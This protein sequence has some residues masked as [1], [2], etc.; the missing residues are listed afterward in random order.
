MPKGIYV[1]TEKSNNHL[2]CHHSEETKKLLSE[3]HKANPTKYWL[4]KKRPSLSGELHPMWKGG[5]VKNSC[6]ICG[7]E[8]K[9][10]YNIYCS[11]ICQGK[12]IKGKPAPMRGR[13]RL[14]IVGELNG[15]WKGGVTPLNEKIRKSFK[16]VEW[17][18]LIKERD[19]YTCQI[20]GKVGGELHSDHLKPFALYPDLRFDINNGRTLCVGCH[21]ATQTYGY[22][23]MYYEGGVQI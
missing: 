18:K 21:R 13:R 4:G 14:D 7:K 20:C 9:G 11:R 15:S 19:K 22:H 2:G 6:L 3:K 12:S 1:R 23:K 16:F 17:S 10:R 8:V 5:F